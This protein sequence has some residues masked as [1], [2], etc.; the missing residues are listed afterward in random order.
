MSDRKENIGLVMMSVF[1]MMGFVSSMSA[2]LFNGILDKI[3]VDMQI[4]IA[5][6][7]Y[8]TSLYA[9]GAIG[10]P[11]IL[12]ILRKMSHSALLKGML[13]ANIL[14]GLLSISISH[15][16]V[17]LFSRFMLGLAGTTYGVLATTKIVALSHPEKIGRN[18]SLLI[19]GG[20][21]ALMVGIPLCRVL[22]HYF[23]WQSIYFILVL[24]MM[25]GLVYFVL[26][27]PA[28]KQNDGKRDFKAELNIAKNK[29][30][31][32]VILSSLLTF[33]GYG[34]F[35]TYMTPYIVEMFPS[36]E[37][38]M[39]VILVLIG[40]CSFLGNLLGG[41]ICDRI[42]FKKALWWGSL[43]QLVIGIIIIMTQKIMLV[44]I[45]F[46]LLWMMIDWFIGLQ[47]NTGINI[48]T[49]RQS[50][51]LV[52]VNG[53]VIQFAQA[54]GAS[55]AAIVISHFG[56][57]WIIILSVMTTLLVVVMIGKRE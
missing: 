19:T 36:L 53:S 14:F 3:A 32:T 37:P 4:S 12:I 31:I 9:Y 7:G 39:S 49:Y 24:L 51:L 2:T 50:S 17:L 6:T 27:L 38:L 45:A 25:V 5:Q 28:V 8:L 54:I 11:V 52:S 48:V 15:F 40:A 41:V 23:S 33:I 26:Y 55:F 10:A 13:L 29:K 47:L 35:Y 42:G 18:L 56:I 44:N 20:S 43:C 46:V 21:V 34:A 57:S 30:V 16:G 1:M 22:I